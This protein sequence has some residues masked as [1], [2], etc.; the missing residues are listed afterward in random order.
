MSEKVGQV[1][2]EFGREA[3]LLDDARVL[4]RCLSALLLMLRTRADHLVL[5]PANGERQRQHR[6]QSG[7]QQRAAP[8]RR[9]SSTEREQLRT[10]AA[11]ASAPFTELRLDQRQRHATAAG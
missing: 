4:A 8:S 6:W 7:R 1:A 10:A 5:G 2:R 9:H 3:E 11:T